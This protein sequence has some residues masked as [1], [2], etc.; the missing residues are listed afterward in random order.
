MYKFKIGDRVRV[1]YTFNAIVN[2][3]YSTG[4]VGIESYPGL[5]WPNELRLIE[6]PVVA[7]SQELADKYRN[8]MAEAFTTFKILK[9]KGFTLQ[10]RSTSL[11]TWEDV[12]ASNPER[13][14]MKQEQV[15]L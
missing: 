6:S 11:H 4:A 3:I 8:L 2:S 13:R 1:R 12:V 9:E 5:F 7:T 14:F 15:V 10:K